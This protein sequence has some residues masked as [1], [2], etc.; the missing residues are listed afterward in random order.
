M[1]ILRALCDQRDRREGSTG[2]ER[3][4]GS[5]ASIGRIALHRRAMHVTSKFRRTA[6]RQVNRAAVVPEKQVVI[7]PAMPVDKLRLCAMREEEFEQFA[8]LRLRKIDYA[9]VKP[10]FTKSVFR[11]VSG[12][13]RATGCTTSATWSFCF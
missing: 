11:P 6:M 8:A 3:L 12:C 2:I 5:P 9:R 7:L 4:S 1:M 13:V 10:S